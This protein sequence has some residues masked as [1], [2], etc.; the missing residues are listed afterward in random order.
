MHHRHSCWTNKM[1]GERVV[2]TQTHPVN[3]GVELSAISVGQHD[4][5]DFSKM[6]Y[7]RI[8]YMHQITSIVFKNFNNFLSPDMPEGAHPPQTPPSP[9]LCTF[10]FSRGVRGLSH[11]CFFY[12]SSPPP[13]FYIM[14]FGKMLAKRM[15]QSTG[16]VF[17]N[18]KM[19]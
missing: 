13:I 3:Y 12:V 17:E 8:P 2:F 16:I 10:V 9:C 1:L 11:R 14:D 5:M 15:Y 4:L 6:L 19:S 7:K 18:V